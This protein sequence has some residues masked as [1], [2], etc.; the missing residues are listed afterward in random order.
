MQQVIQP[1]SPYVLSPGTKSSPSTLNVTLVRHA[2]SRYNLAQKVASEALT[3]PGSTQY[4]EDLTVKY[5]HALSDCLLTDEGLRQCAAAVKHFEDEDVSIVFTSPMRRALTTTTEIFKGHKSAPLVVV[6]PCIS[7]LLHDA[8]D[9]PGDIHETQKLFPQYNYDA[10][11]AYP[12]PSKWFLEEMGPNKHT[13]ALMSK[14]PK[15]SP[16]VVCKYMKEISPE[17]IE[18]P[19]E[20]QNRVNRAKETVKKIVEREKPEGKVI[21]VG[22]G[23]FFYYLTAKSF[24]EK[25]EPAG[26]TFLKNASPFAF[27]L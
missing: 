19:K 4:I 18:T 23:E 17:T 22:H 10:W 2:Q 9:I 3:P 16:E 21:L 20:A 27:T 6:L 5:D 24:N 13:E 7:E 14:M 11:K 12:D 25:D 26:A 8:G 15:H 1:D